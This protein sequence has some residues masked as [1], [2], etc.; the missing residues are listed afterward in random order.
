MTQQSG[1]P[2]N[3]STLAWF[4]RECSDKQRETIVMKAIEAANKEQR[5]VIKEAAA[6]KEKTRPYTITMV[7]DENDLYSY[8]TVVEARNIDEAI[9]KA[10][11]EAV[12]V[13]EIE[14]RRYLYV[15]N[16]FVGDLICLH[17]E[18]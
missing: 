18:I 3:M 2:P 11:D 8:G 10:K 13:N 12:E 4:V 5:R 7:C 15:V 6:M 16:A 17:Y 14:D 1:K 9:E